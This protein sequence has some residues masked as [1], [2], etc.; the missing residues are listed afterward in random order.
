MACRAVFSAPVPSGVD[1]DGRA[2]QAHVFDVDG[3]DLFFLQPGKDPIQ[4][5]S[6]APAIHSR[7]DG[8]HQLPKCFGKPRHLQP[9]ST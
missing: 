2:V 9:C 8:M 6:F 7:V 4:D 3:Q 5:A 1:F